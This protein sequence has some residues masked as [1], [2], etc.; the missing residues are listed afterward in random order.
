MANKK[1]GFISVFRSLQD[2]WLWESDEPFD[3]RS[4]WI[5]LL[6]SVNHKENKIQVGRSVVTIH[7]GQMWTSYVK[8]ARRWH[9]DRKRVYRYIKML[10]S[11]GM[12]RVDGTPNGTL[13]TVVNY[14]KFAYQGNARGTTDG[15]TCGTMSG[16]T[17]GATDGAQ[18]II[19]NNDN[20]LNNGTKEPAAPRG[21]TEWQ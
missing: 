17:E 15:A 11:D 19:N 20:K 12:I 10:I 4:A 7:A 14:S 3:I 9:W 5:D 16:A 2:H 13:L 18:T 8:L 21:G 6:M 1:T